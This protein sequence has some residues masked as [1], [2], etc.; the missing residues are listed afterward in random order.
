MRARGGEIVLRFDVEAIA[1]AA[2][3]WEVIHDGKQPMLL[4][5]GVVL[6]CI[7]V[8]NSKELP[9]PRVVGKRLRVLT[10]SPRVL[11]NDVENAFEQRARYR[12]Q[13]GLYNLPIDFEFL[14]PASMEALH[15]RLD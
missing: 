11:M 3:P 5:R 13:D 6:N 10:I 12:M 2:L 1:L 15:K 8:I 14:T 9:P 4:T 7:R